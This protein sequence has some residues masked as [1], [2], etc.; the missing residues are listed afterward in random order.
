MGSLE[1][2]KRSSTRE[3]I[4]EKD[5]E[6]ESLAMAEERALRSRCESGVRAAARQMSTMREGSVSDRRRESAARDFCLEVR[7]AEWSEGLRMADG[8]LSVAA[9]ADR[10]R[11]W[12]F[13]LRSPTDSAMKMEIGRAHV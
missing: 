4:E 12:S 3:R 2:S 10:W 11:R 13:R 8:D 1:D 9:E 7:I 6:E 5:W